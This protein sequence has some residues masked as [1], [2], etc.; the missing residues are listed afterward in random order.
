MPDSGQTPR[1]LTLAADTALYQAKAAGRNCVVA[2]G[3]VARTDTSGTAP[4]RVVTLAAATAAPTAHP[5]VLLAEIQRLTQR[6]RQ[7]AQLLHSALDAVVALSLIH[8]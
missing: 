4:P 3:Q 5:Q 8:I 2:H 7:L 6:E 1:E